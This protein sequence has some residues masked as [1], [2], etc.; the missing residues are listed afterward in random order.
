M[1]PL[2]SI[3]IAAAAAA[4]GLTHEPGCNLC[5]GLVEPTLMDIPASIQKYLFGGLPTWRHRPDDESVFT[6]QGDN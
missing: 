6:W 4:P 2:F 3:K 5:S 1:L